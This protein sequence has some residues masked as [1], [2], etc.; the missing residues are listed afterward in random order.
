M[1][2]KVIL[3]MELNF[4]TIKQL[5][6]LTKERLRDV[7]NIFPLLFDAEESINTSTS[8]KSSILCAKVSVKKK[9][10]LALFKFKILY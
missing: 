7:W 4:A 2:I 9:R 6:T 1:A 10:V 8:N 3:I 5:L